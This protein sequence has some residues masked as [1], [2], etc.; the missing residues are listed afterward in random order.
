MRELNAIEVD[1]IS[2]AGFAEN[3]GYAVGSA[4]ESAGKAIGS[5]IAD[6][7]NRLKQYMYT[8]TYPA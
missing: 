8:G 4:V 3:L 2:G 5:A 1:N 6:A 7:N